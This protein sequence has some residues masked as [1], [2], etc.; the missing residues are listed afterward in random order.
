MRHTALAILG[1]TVLTSHAFLA[2][3]PPS[4]P[5]VCSQ[6]GYHCTVAPGDPVISLW[7]DS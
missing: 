3:I 7:R 2:G 1:F 6:P 4:W 5:R